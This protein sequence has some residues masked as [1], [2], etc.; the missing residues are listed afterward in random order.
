MIYHGVFNKHPIAFLGSYATDCGG[1]DTIP[2]VSI[3]AELLQEIMGSPGEGI[4]FYEGLMISH[5]IGTV[6]AAV[7]PYETRH[8]MGFLDTPL[9]VCIE[10]VKA[11]R[12]ARGN[13]KP[14]DPKRTLTKDYVAVGQAK[15]NATIQGF[16]V[17][18][19]GYESALFD[20]RVWM[21]T[22]LEEHAK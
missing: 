21:S 3:V 22:L 11:R 1:C 5:M 14:F 19:I 6:G 7:R 20:A 18:D 4:V 17:V 10:R 13:D 9:D 2:K 15:R 12:L 8:I 16:R